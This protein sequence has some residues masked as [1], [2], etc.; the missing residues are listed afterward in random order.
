MIRAYVM[1]H[2]ST[3]ISPSPEGW[4]QIGLSREGWG[5][6]RAGADFLLRFT[7][8]GSPR[9][10]WGISS[11]L[12]RA[13]ETLAIAADILQLPVLQSVFKLRAYDDD[14]ETASSYEE[15]NAEGFSAVLET[16]RETDSVPLIVCHRSSTGFLGKWTNV[17]DRD[18]DYRYDALL[19]EGGVLALTEH[20]IIPL[21]RAVEANWPA[22]LKC[23]S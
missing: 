11:D 8:E 18:P 13:E 12:R 17:I 15:R 14:R 21:F 20:G 4:K 1:R 23:Q 5:E 22:N 6:A 19:L 16:A 2:G 3:S 9:P 10:D 7:R